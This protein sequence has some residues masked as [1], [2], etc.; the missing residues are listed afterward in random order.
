MAFH[1][2]D[3]IQ[4]TNSLKLPEGLRLAGRDVPAADGT[5]VPLYLFRLPDGSDMEMVAVPAGDFVMGADDSD[6]PDWEKP[7]HNHPMASPYWIGR[8]DVT[9]GQFKTFCAAIGRAEPEKAYF[10]GKLGEDRDCHPVVMV[11]WDDAQAYC[12][13][14]GLVLPSEAEWEKAARGADGRK[15]P[16]GS[17][18]P[19]Q[20]RTTWTHRVQGTKS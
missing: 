14:A 19:L 18:G 12:A 3:K 8:N 11:S 13:W 2:L 16:W 15:Y 5:Q 6:A 4:V 7:R 20:R 10:D 9:R 1:K 17:T